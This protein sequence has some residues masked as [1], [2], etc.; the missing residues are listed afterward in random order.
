MGVIARPPLVSPANN[1]PSI[2]AA[3]WALCSTF[4]TLSLTPGVDVSPYWQ[5]RP[6]KALEIDCAWD[7]PVWIQR[8]RT[9]ESLMLT[10]E[11]LDLFPTDAAACWPHLRRL[12]FMGCRGNLL[13]TGVFTLSNL[14]HLYMNPGP[15]EP[16]A[17]EHLH[18]LP[19][20][21]LL[22]LS[23]TQAPVPPAVFALTRLQQ[24]Y[25]FACG[26][27]HIPEGLRALQQLTI[28]DLGGNDFSQVP[29]WIGELDQLTYLFLDMQQGPLNRLPDDLMQLSHL[30]PCP[31]FGEDLPPARSKVNY[32]TYGGP[33]AITAFPPHVR[34]SPHLFQFLIE[35]GFDSQY[36]H[37]EP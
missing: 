23:F 30:R 9:L 2:V 5:N 1:Y 21:Q 28:L 33:H 11:N 16:S 26:L 29:S 3:L 7:A 6:W 8:V 10:Q 20:L 32:H 31:F 27:L 18:R 15:K 14:T 4:H 25:L 34:V 12:G 19:H 22:D 37:V 17:Y 13:P 36:F 35:R 24:L